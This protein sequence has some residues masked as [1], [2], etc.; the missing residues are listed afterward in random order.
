MKD[1]LI[2]RGV[3]GETRVVEIEGKQK[4]NGGYVINRTTYQYG[5]KKTIQPEISIT[6]G[7]AKRTIEEQYNLEYNSKVKSYLDKGY[8]KLPETVDINNNEQIK[9]FVLD[10]MGDGVTDSNGFKKHMLAK[11]ADSVATKTFDAIPF[12]YGSRKIDGQRL[13]LYWNGNS[14][15][16][17]SRGGQKFYSLEHLTKHP[18]LIAFFQKHPDYVLDGELY[19]HGM[20]LQQISGLARKEKE[21][22]PILEYYVYDIM[23]DTLTFRDRLDILNQIKEELNLGFDPEREW[24]DDDLKIQMVPHE[25]VSGWLN[26]EKLHDRYVAEGWEGLVI[27]DPDAFYT[28]GGRTKAMIKIKKYAEETYTVVGKE[29]GLRGSEDM[30][31][32]MQM[33]DGRTF[34]AK[35]FG[36]RAQKQ[37]YWDNFETTYKG[38]KGDCKYFYYSNDGIPLQPSFKAFRWDLE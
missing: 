25:K 28:Y 3:K 21:Q 37:E 10:N 38:H 11:Q 19:K 18:K 9:Q 16:T 5:G 14:I 1:I 26:C 24:N 8:K 27:R 35:P 13:S 12:W 4:D 36:D 34:K 17:A 15:E 6:A 23:D 7:K 2:T 31:F 33:K 20:A 32:I 30:V 29:A 22:A